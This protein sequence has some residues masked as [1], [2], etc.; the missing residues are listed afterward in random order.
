MVIKLN[1]QYIHLLIENHS[2]QWPPR[3]SCIREGPT[4]SWGMDLESWMEGSDCSTNYNSFYRDIHF[5]SREQ[6][7]P[8][9][10]NIFQNIKKIGTHFLHVHP[11]ILCL[12]TNFKEE[13]TFFVS[14]IKRQ[15][16][17][18]TYDYLHDIFL[19]F[20]PMPHKM[21]FFVKNLCGDIECPNL[22][23]EFIFEFFWHF[24]NYFLCFF[25][26]RFI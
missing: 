25:Y 18:W 1:C 19:S 4:E 2:L 20:L 5:G 7:N 17:V 3:E 24:E 8:L 12:Y 16:C 9:L 11:N 13:K 14:Y 21:F 6:M 23:A 22:H 15:I 26:N 10:E